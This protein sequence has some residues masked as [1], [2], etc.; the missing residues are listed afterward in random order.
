MNNERMPAQALTTEDVIPTTEKESAQYSPEAR[1]EK[2]EQ[3]FHEASEEIKKRSSAVLETEDILY[4]ER[5]AKS[6]AERVLGQVD[7]FV[8]SLNDLQERYEQQ[9][10]RYKAQAVA[11]Y[12][13][14]MGALRTGKALGYDAERLSKEFARMLTEEPAFLKKTESVDISN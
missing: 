13:Q 10:E 8:E 1:A 9:G 3:D 5:P 14:Q 7:I 12:I 4:C 2:I 6:E 11:M